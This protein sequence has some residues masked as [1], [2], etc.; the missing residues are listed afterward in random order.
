MA[1]LFTSI[2]PLGDVIG[3]ILAIFMIEKFGRKKMYIGGLLASSAIL[4]AF[5]IL[6]WY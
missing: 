4:L 2:M 5:A 6:G 3:C 1:R